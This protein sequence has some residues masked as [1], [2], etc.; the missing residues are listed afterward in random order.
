MANPLKCN[1]CA[2]KPATVHLTQ[3]VNNKVHNVDLRE[4]CAQSK[5]VTNPSGFVR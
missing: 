3:I 2:R 5:G 1:F 4:E